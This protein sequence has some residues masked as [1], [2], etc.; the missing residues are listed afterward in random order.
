MCAYERALILATETSM[1]RCPVDT[2]TAHGHAQAR[3]HN[4]G[5]NARTEKA[6]TC[7]HTPAKRVR[8]CAYARV[9]AC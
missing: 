3:L 8:V 7:I 4:E 5:S 9:R 6:R 2:C 1:H